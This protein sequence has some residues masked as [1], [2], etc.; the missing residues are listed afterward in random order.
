MT[1]SN[2]LSNKHN[3]A[4]VQVLTG[5]VNL[6]KRT[7]DFALKKVDVLLEQVHLISKTL[8]NVNVMLADYGYKDELLYAEGILN[9][10]KPLNYAK[11]TY[12]KLQDILT[13]E[14]ETLG[15]KYDD[16]L[17]GN[18][19]AEE[20]LSLVNNLLRDDSEYKKCLNEIESTITPNYVQNIAETSSDI[21]ESLSKIGKTY[22]DVLPISRKIS[23]ELEDLKEL[24]L[25]TD[26]ANDILVILHE[27]MT[28]L[29]K[30][31]D[32]S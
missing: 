20:Y 17:V 16:L 18:I 4:V 30:H 24:F 7:V 26:F 10:D 12:V 31:T 21:A 25:T 13:K 9:I 28:N 22:A 6:S 19:S 11:E 3:N 14:Y 8:D 29:V 1:N 2:I 27:S 15:S 32:R 23:S 5:E